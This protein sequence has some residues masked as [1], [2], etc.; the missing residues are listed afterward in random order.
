MGFFILSEKVRTDLLWASSRDC[1][2]LFYART[3]LAGPDPSLVI[4][5]FIF[6]DQLKHAGLAD[7][8]DTGIPTPPFSV[9]SSLVGISSLGGFTATDLPTCPPWLLAH[10]I[11]S[12]AALSGPIKDRK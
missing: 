9:P 11:E 7:S 6:T 4:G 2:L 3:T 8:P 12:P 1:W 10:L 5:R